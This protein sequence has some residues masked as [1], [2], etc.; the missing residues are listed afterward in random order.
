MS[1][2][3]LELLSLRPAPL[4]LTYMGH[5]GTS[6][7]AYIQYVAVDPTVAPPR[8]A[9][10]FSERLLQL[11]QWH[12]TDYRDAHAFAE[13]RHDSARRGQLPRATALTRGFFQRG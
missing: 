5:P 1:R 6:G 4:Q 10:H 9:R 7:A 3:Q 13:L 11:P 2:P 8:L 12:V